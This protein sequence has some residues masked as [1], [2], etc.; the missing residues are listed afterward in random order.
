MN[1]KYRTHLCEDIG[2]VDIGKE[3]SVSGWVHRRRDHGGVIFIDLRDVSGILQLVFNP[4]NEDLFKTAEKMR[5]EFVLSVSGV[6]R[7]RPEG[8]INNDMKTGAVELLVE[9]GEVLNASITPP[10]HHDE[11][12]NEDIRLKYRYLDL[13]REDMSKNIKIRHEITR[14]LREYLNKASYFEIETPILTKATPEGARDYLVPSRTQQGNFFALPQ[15]PQLFKQLLMMSGFDRYY[16]IARCF[17]DEDLRADRQPEFTQL[18]VEMSFV[19]QED[20][21]TEMESMVRELFKSVLD[22]DLDKEFV[23]VT[24]AEAMQRF[25]SDSPHLGIDMELTEVSDL[26]QEV[27]FKVFSGPAND[28]DSRVACLVLRDSSEMSRKQI[29]DYT[30][31]VSNYGAKGLAYIKVNEIEKGIDGLQSPILKFLNDEVISQLIEKLSLENGNTVFFGADKKGI[32]NASLGALRV[33]MAEDFGLIH[34]GWFPL[35]VTDFPM[36][37]WDEK[38]KRWSAEHHPFTSPINLDP[39]ELKTNP[40]DSLSQGY[41][42]VLNG[43]EI[44]GGSIRIHSEAMQQSVFSILGINAEEADEKFGFFLEALKYGCPPH[45]GIAF[46]IDRIVMLMTGSSSIRDVIA[47]P[48]TQTASCLLTD[49]PSHAGKGQLNELGISIKK[50]N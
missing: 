15:S 31:F 46:G 12:T 43:H 45:G 7:E 23:Q 32:V 38:E 5:S 24:H 14:S 30:D 13:R 10:F 44:G 22:V 18:D 28:H 35:W 16:Q 48:K 25:G 27:E 36:F 42:M 20:V 33:K 3:L 11:A 41:D 29:D 1:G 37:H 17:R 2:I 40:R 21:K 8:T 39:E 47:F 26:M 9:S 50:K 49:A 34:D 6:V 19:E 4:E